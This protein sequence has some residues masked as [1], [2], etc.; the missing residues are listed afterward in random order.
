MSGYAS[1]H[2]LCWDEAKAIESMSHFV[3]SVPA[4][5]NDAPVEL[6][7][8]VV[9]SITQPLGEALAA[10]QGDEEPCWCAACIAE[11]AALN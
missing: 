11:A 3:A 10:A 7:Q 4:D 5:P 8:L 9:L 1:A 2:E 6:L